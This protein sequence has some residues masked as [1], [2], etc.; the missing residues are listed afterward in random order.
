MGTRPRPPVTRFAPSPTGHL[1]LGHAHSA[2]FAERLAREAGGRFL[3]RIED[4]DQGR[5]RAEFE[6]AI[7]VDL[8][9]L[10]LQWETP[11]RRQSAHMADYGRARETLSERGLV[12]PCFCTRREI[13]EEAAKAGLA[14]HGPEGVIYPGTCR[15]LDAG[16]RQRRVDAG[17]AYALRL[18]MAGATAEAGPLTWR[19]MDGDGG[20]RV[21]TAEPE[22]FG[23]VVLARKDT[24]TSYHLACTLDDHDQGVTLVSRGEDLFTATHVHRLLQALLGLDTP[25]YRHHGLL[26][27]ADGQ[28]LAKRDG[29][30]TLRALREAGRTP[31]EVRKM[32]RF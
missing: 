22:I 3:V 13:Q 31:A 27:N 8:A 26:T 18:D 11:V 25:D 17:E 32:A 15:K 28:R 1:H 21:V 10:G 12:Y 16:T 7:L 5:C 24:P 6:D 20:G 23:D 2:L 4:I 30:L 29:G 14:P 19:E 9:W